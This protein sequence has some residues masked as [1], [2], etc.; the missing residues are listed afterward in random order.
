MLIEAA[1]QYWFE[2][3]A[4]YFIAKWWDGL[5]QPVTDRRRLAQRPNDHPS[6]S[7]HC[8]V[9]HGNS[10]PTGGAAVAEPSSVDRSTRKTIAYVRRLADS[11]RRVQPRF[12]S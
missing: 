10:Q 3:R 2:P 6:R 4:S 12:G 9:L 5:P 11:E 1:W 7:A 8:K